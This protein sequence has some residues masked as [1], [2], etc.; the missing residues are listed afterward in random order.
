MNFLSFKL[1]LQARNK[2]RVVC[3]KKID[4]SRIWNEALNELD[5]V[6]AETIEESVI[7]SS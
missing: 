2:R 3:L 5:P 6:G 4:Q 1:N 7:I